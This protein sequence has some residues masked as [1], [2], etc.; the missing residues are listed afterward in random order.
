MEVGCLR[1]MKVLALV[2]YPHTYTYEV[3]SRITY[4]SNFINFPDTCP[5]VFSNDIHEVSCI[6][7]SQPCSC[8]HAKVGTIANYACKD[9]LV[10]IDANSSV[11]C[12]SDGQWSEKV[13]PCIYLKV[14]PGCLLPTH[15]QNGE[16]KLVGRDDYLENS[17]APSLSALHMICDNGYVAA[18]SQYF[19]CIKNTWTPE[20]N[21]GHCLRTC[22]PLYP[23]DTYDV[24]CELNGQS[25]DCETPIENTIAKLSCMPYYK[26]DR[27]TPILKCQNG[28][29]DPPP[30]PCQP[31]KCISQLID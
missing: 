11:V 26:V 4:Y 22:P 3:F 17:H 14:D 8:E 1:L 20:L 10:S 27:V 21:R 28:E 15:P 12:Q 5:A 6:Y 23:T 29:W 9:P 16:Y 2:S 31:G 24:R 13:K 30:T 7:N 19:F 18:G 25:V